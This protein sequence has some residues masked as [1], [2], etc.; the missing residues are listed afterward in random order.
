[1]SYLDLFFVQK[2]FDINILSISSVFR[3]APWD[4]VN[5]LEASV[6]VTVEA[7]APSQNSPTVAGEGASDGTVGIGSDDSTSFISSAPSNLPS[8]SPGPTSLGL[9][10]GAPLGAAALL[11]TVV[12]AWRSWA[13]RGGESS[14]SKLVHGLGKDESAIPAVARAGK[15]APACLPAC[16]AAA[17]TDADVR[18]E[19]DMVFPADPGAAPV[20]AVIYCPASPGQVFD[21]LPRD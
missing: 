17:D 11:G 21:R 18:I 2:P 19:M 14:A 5:I 4:S 20:A 13:R 16:A 3:R 12:F 10:V 7:A 9:V 15:R 8:P 1:M 6:L